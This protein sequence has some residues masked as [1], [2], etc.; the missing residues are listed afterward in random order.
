MVARRTDH[1]SFTDADGKAVLETVRSVC[2]ELPHVIESKSW[3]N[4]TFKVNGKPFAILDSYR[5]EA[6]IWFRCDPVTRGILL[7]QPGF[8]KSPYDRTEKA[9]CRETDSVSTADLMA[10]V[11]LGFNEAISE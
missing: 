5:G 10:L 3:G 4:P 7:S 9:L 1:E 2:D 8:F 11:F 6:C